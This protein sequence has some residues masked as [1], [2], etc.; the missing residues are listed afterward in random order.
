VRANKARRAGDEDWGIGVLGH[1]RERKWPAH[2]AGQ[3][4]P[5]ASGGRDRS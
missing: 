4:L 2:P 1:G 5:P 3:P